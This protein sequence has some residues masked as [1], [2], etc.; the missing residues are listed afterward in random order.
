MCYFF[1]KL[2][3]EVSIVERNRP[4]RAQIFIWQEGQAE[5]ASQAFSVR[6]EP[7]QRSAAGQAGTHSLGLGFPARPANCV[8][9]RRRHFVAGRESDPLRT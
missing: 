1:L 7:G 4:L 3:F 8:V 5:Q 2:D 9:V 6:A